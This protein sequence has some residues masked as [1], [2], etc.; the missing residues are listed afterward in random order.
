MANKTS[1][2]F[3][4]TQQH[5]EIEDIRDDL[6]I[7]KN[8]NVVAIIQTNAVNF[9]LLSETE[10]DAM[11]FA[12]AGLLNALSF[13]IQVAVRSKRT[14]ISSYIMKLESAKANQSNPRLAAQISRYTQFVRELIAR[15]NVLA[16][17][18][19]VIIPYFEIKLSTANPF[20]NLGGQNKK[21][22]GDKI[23]LL[24]RA[25]VGLQPKV[26]FIIKQLA[27]IGLQGDTLN[28]QQLVE[29]FYDFYNA[30]VSREQKVAL[31]T[32]EYTAKF[33]EPAVATPA[34]NFK[35]PSV[36]DQ[37]PTPKLPPKAIIEN[38]AGPK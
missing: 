10:Q 6:V 23:A 32:S 30:D 19:Y 5:L 21:F 16:K 35:P 4:T 1:Q 3:Y 17:K 18:F 7:L 33:V 27:R 34:V 25:K 11:I 37:A 8:G 15:N 31:T 36:N 20:A 12:Y 9:D 38:N 14:D 13:P 22:V 24:E 26:E 28:T 29:L 2:T